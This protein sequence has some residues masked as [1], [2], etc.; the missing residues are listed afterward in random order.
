MHYFPSGSNMGTSGLDPIWEPHLVQ[1]PRMGRGLV[2][3]PGGTPGP[4]PMRDMSEASLMAGGS[5][6]QFRAAGPC[7][8]SGTAL[9][10]HRGLSIELQRLI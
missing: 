3:E 6:V 10:S 5:S 9:F 1:L 8:G 7:S 2:V 4:H